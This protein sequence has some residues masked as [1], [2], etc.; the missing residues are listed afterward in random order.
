[1]KQVV[2]QFHLYDRR[3]VSENP[4]GVIARTNEVRTKQSCFAK[5]LAMTLKEPDTIE[6]K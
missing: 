5:A 6:K 1:M 4:P 3:I 2:R